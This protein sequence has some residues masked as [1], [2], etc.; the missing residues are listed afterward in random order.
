M[1]LSINEQM[2]GNKVRKNFPKKVD[3]KNRIFTR[4]GIILV[5]IAI[6]TT[7][8]SSAHSFVFQMTDSLSDNFE[9]DNELLN[10]EDFS[11]YAFNFGMNPLFPQTGDVGVTWDDFE[12]IDYPYLPITPSVVVDSFGRTHLFWTNYRNGRSMYHQLIY[13][14]GTYAS[15]ELLDS[16]SMNFEYRLDA[17]ADKIGRVHLAYSWG[18]TQDSSHTYYR[19]WYNGSWSAIERIDPGVDGGGY[20][21]PSH[22]PQIAVDQYNTP[23][24]IWSGANQAAMLE[25]LTAYPVFYQMR[26]GVNS[27]SQILFTRY[28][29]PYNFG[30]AITNDDTIHVVLSQ[31]YG[32]IYYVLHR[33]RYLDKQIGEGSWGLEE[34]IG[35]EEMDGGKMYVPGPGLLATNNTLHLFI[36]SISEQLGPSIVYLNK[37]GSSWSVPI[38]L[39]TEASELGVNIPEAAATPRGDIILTWPNNKYEVTYTGGIHIMLYDTILG[40]W[41]DAQLITGNYTTAWSQSVAYNEF[42]DEINVLWRDNHPVSGQGTYYIKGIMDTDFDKLSNLNELEVYFTDPMDSDSDDDLLLDGDEI[43]YGLDPNNPD[44]DLDLILDGWEIHYGLD[45]LNTTDA[46]VDFEP[47]GLINLEEFNYGTDPYLADTDSDSL[48]D[49]DEVSI[50]GTHPN[51]AD[52]DYD[53]LTDGD[54]IL[55]YGTNAT[56]PDSEGDGMPDGYEIANSLNPLFNDSGLDP[57]L[58]TITN[59]EEYGFGTNPNSNDTDTDLLDDYEEIFVYFTNPLVSDTDSDLLTDHYEVVIDPLDDQYLLNNTY[60]TNPN[61]WDTDGDGLSDY[62]EIAIHG[63]NPILADT[64]GDLITDGYEVYYGLNPFF[65]DAS[66]N[67][68]TDDLTNYQEFLYNGDPFDADTDDDRLLDSEEVFWGTSLTEDDTDGDYLTDYLEVIYYGTDPTNPDTDFDG[69]SDLFELYIFHSSPFHNDTDGDSLLDGD[70]VF[71]YGSHPLRV[72]TDYD[73]LIDPIEVAFGSAPYDS[74]TDNDGMDDYFEY[75]YNFNPLY[76]DSYE[77]FDGDGLV[78]VAEYWYFSNPTIIDTDGDLLNDSAEVYIYL[79]S[80]IKI[81]TDGDGLSDYSEAIIYKTSTT[82]PDMDDDGLTDGEEILQYATNPKNPDTDFDGYSDYIEIEE[83]TDPLRASSNPGRRLLTILSS[84]FGG[85]IGGLFVY[86]V[87]PYIFNLRKRNEELKWI[88]TGIQKRQEKSDTM[89]NNSKLTSE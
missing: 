74:D 68:D 85:T 36:N 40:H 66:Q 9:E 30:I 75:I 2:G 51:R 18:S 3:G 63:T 81:D 57:D 39:T 78:N 43:S 11:E 5:I 23:H 34:I 19:Y 64:D 25:D 53:E 83:G 89:L 84:V 70:E 48:T 82:D 73:G 6:L 49:G 17:V 46:S 42:T 76:D 88:R 7:T 80:P 32:E 29:K 4:L 8:I 26:L 77:D 86:Y 52:T 28:A 69:L 24:I 14:D 59:L 37:T 15:L 22:S 79:S 44:Q 72:D 45:P 55:I 27:W 67:Y 31:R 71:I 12:I 33:I 10:N 20:S 21:L 38:I 50:Y 1:I 35:Q 54:E 87:L 16:R 41:T 58:D 56:N 62:V 61:L 47:D 60:Q 13:A 65:N